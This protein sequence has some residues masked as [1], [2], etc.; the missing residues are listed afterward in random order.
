MNLFKLDVE[1][2]K[3]EKMQ[4][5]PNV[6]A[7]LRQAQTVRHNRYLEGNLHASLDIAVADEDQVSPYYRPKPADQLIARYMS[8]KRVRYARGRHRTLVADSEDFEPVEGV[9]N[10]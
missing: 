4:T 3:L 7:H 1:A 10:G 8:P 5:A 2:E 6:E 9:P